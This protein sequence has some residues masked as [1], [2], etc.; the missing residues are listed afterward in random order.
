MFDTL[1]VLPKATVCLHLS[2]ESLRSVLNV[3]AKEE[4]PTLLNELNPL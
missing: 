2:V 3:V 4:F 1:V